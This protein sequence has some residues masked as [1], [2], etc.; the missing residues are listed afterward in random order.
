MD[1]FHS[2]N[3]GVQNEVVYK[4]CPRGK[5]GGKGQRINHTF[6]KGR[7][8]KKDHHAVSFARK[9]VGVM[10]VICFTKVFEKVRREQGGGP[11]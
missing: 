2:H 10:R 8:V 9:N 4:T 3:T 7:G 6:G 1:G 11:Y 5:V